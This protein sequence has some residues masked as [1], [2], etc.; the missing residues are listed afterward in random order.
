MWTYGIGPPQ[1]AIPFSNKQKSCI[2]FRD[3]HC[4]ECDSGGSGGST[5]FT[6]ICSLVFFIKWICFLG[7]CPVETDWMIFHKLCV[8]QRVL[9]K[10]TL[11]NS[12]IQSLE[13][14]G[15]TVM[16]NTWYLSASV[17]IDLCYVTSGLCYHKWNWQLMS[18]NA[19]LWDWRLDVLSMCLFSICNKS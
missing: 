17:W 18:S 13:K 14:H 6:N 4:S 3:I 10:Q 5:R 2:A 15:T 9:G 19:Q 11:I 1:N 16:L 7:H 12:S 8:R